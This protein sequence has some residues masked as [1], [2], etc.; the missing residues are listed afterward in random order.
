MHVAAARINTCVASAGSR[1][2]ARG[3]LVLQGGMVFLFFS[4]S[5]LYHVMLSV[6]CSSEEITLHTLHDLIIQVE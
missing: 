5:S 2:G 3:G 4:A 6:R 1:S